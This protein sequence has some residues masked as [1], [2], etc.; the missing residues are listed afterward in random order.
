M[1][2][3]GTVEAVSLTCTH[4]TATTTTL[5]RMF[6]IAGLAANGND[7]R[8]REMAPATLHPI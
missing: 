2:C 4:A 7:E 6:E 5:P 1:T 3:S 8:D